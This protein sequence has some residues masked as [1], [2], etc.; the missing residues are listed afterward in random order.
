MHKEVETRLSQY[1][2]P[3]LGK[4]LRAA[5]AIKNIVVRED[6]LEIEIVF[7]YPFATIKQEMIIA[8]QEWIKPITDDK[9][10]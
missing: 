3:Y 8:I 1:Q 10:N 7:G 6:D 2:D 5:K 4:D 9:K